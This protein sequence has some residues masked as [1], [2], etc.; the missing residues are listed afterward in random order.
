MC[1]ETTST[2]LAQPS[3][4]DP[5]RITLEQFLASRIPWPDERPALGIEDMEAAIAK[6]ALGSADRS[7]EK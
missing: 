3:G 6:G 5:A 4:D 2:F 1:K 7:N